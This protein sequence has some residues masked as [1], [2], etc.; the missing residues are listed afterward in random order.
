MI[1]HMQQ[2]EPEAP[3]LADHIKDAQQFAKRFCDYQDQHRR[4]MFALR[5]ATV[6][7]DA[8]SRLNDD[9]RRLALELK[10]LRMELAG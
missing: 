2:I 10:K 1:I 4:L 9:L 7:T 3:L 5:D 8:F 6:P